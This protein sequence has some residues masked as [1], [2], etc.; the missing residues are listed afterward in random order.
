MYLSTYTDSVT[1]YVVNAD[2]GADVAYLISVY[3][4]PVSVGLLAAVTITFRWNDGEA[5]RSKPYVLPLTGLGGVVSDS[6]IAIKGNGTDITLEVALTG[7]A[8]YKF[9]YGFTNI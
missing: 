6:F 7:S 5:T 3:A 1:Q 9:G 4:C 2:E 8:S